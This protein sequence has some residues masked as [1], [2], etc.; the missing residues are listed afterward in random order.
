MSQYTDPNNPDP[1]QQPAPAQG[2]QD[3][4]TSAQQEGQQPGSTDD[5]PGVGD[6]GVTEPTA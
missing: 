2:Q 6:E 1:G 3:A 4:G 5:E